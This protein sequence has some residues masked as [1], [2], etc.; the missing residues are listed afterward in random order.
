MQHQ[1]NNSALMMAMVMVEL[2]MLYAFGWNE[3]GQ[4]RILPCPM[5]V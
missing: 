4:V 1:V 3:Y 5:V 2:A